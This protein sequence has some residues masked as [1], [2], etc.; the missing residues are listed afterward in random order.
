MSGATNSGDR[1]ISAGLLGVCLVA[2]LQLVNKESLDA[3]LWVTVYAS[4]VAIPCL[5]SVILMLDAQNRND[6][7]TLTWHYK[8]LLLIGIW[9][10]VI[11]IISVFF[12]LSLIAGI[13]STVLSILSFICYLAYENRIRG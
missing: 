5:A 8:Y 4:A 3:C 12:H 6:N 1:L 7:S 2:I 9:A 11:A 10:A 13:I